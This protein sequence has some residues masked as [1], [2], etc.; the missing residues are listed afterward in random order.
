MRRGRRALLRAIC[1]GAL[2]AG[3]SGRAAFGGQAPAQV[4][5]SAP[6]NPIDYATARFDRIAHAMRITE[7]ITVDGR[8]G[9]PAWQRAEPAANFIQWEPEPGQP[10]SEK[11]EVRFLYTDDNLYIGARCWDSD[12]AHL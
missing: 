2:A 3:A 10:S 4:K 1:F 6:A 8:L 7:R 5:G 12:S 11:T 9:E